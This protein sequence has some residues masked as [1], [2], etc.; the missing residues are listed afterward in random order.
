MADKTRAAIKRRKKALDKQM[1]HEEAE[2]IRSEL[3]RLSSEYTEQANAVKGC[4]E[5]WAIK[6]RIRAKIGHKKAYEDMNNLSDEKILRE[7]N[8]QAKV[9]NKESTLY[10]MLVYMCAMHSEYGWAGQRLINSCKQVETLLIQI[11]NGS[12]RIVQLMDE[13]KED[14]CIDMYEFM[15]EYEPPKSDRVSQKALIMQMREPLTIFIYNLIRPPYNFRGKRI[16]RAIKAIERTTEQYIKS[17]DGVG[18]MI[19]YLSKHGLKISRNGEVG[20]KI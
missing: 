8:Q 19:A 14:Y 3:K 11:N 4:T 20:L 1:K 16:M 9:L 13:L 7:Y 5:P 10:A 15:E 18:D 12:R 17:S 2:R 6:Q